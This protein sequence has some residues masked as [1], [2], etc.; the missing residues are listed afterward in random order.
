ME[1]RAAEA[2]AAVAGFQNDLRNAMTAAK[3]MAGGPALDP[4][5]VDELKECAASARAHC[6]AQRSHSL[7]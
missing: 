7:L 3:D 1:R 5:L 4:G 2:K 6:S